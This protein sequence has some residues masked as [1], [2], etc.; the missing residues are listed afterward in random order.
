[1]HCPLIWPHSSAPPAWF[2][3]HHLLLFIS[4]SSPLCKIFSPAH[5][6]LFFANADEGSAAQIQIPQSH[7][8]QY[9]QI[10]V[11]I[12]C[13]KQENSYEH[14]HIFT[15]KFKFFKFCFC[16]EYLLLFF[17]FFLFC[18]E[19]LPYTQLHISFCLS[20]PPVTPLL[21]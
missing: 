10:G 12:I 5:L 6:L 2:C 8:L 19:L 9:I 18:H 17:V 13:I 21:L 3:A 1:M 7:T 15:F 20:H 4:F 16:G 14:E 11:I